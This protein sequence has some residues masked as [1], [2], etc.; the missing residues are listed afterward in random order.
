MKKSK[1]SNNKVKVDLIEH[2]ALHSTNMVTEIL[3]DHLINHHYYN[4]NINPE[5]NKL[6]D[7]AGK[8]L[9]K[10]YQSIANNSEYYK[11]L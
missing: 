11:S 4:S 7:K 6:I 1:K 9:A 8:S 3:E 5:Y 10:A 2:E